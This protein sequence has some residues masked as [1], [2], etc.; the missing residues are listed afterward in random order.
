MESIVARKMHRTLEPFQGMIYFSPE[1]ARE[2]RELGS[3][4]GPSGYF[5]SLAAPM[6]LVSVGSA[7]RLTRIRRG[8]EVT[9]AVRRGW[10]WLSVTGAAD[11]IRPDDR[12]E[13]VDADAVRTLLRDVFRAA[14]GIHEDFD[15]YDRVMSEEA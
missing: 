9:I 12:P 1:A 7:A 3:E 10:R 2:Y 8:S 6:G 13:G 5:A 15:E 14:G 4:R 11:I